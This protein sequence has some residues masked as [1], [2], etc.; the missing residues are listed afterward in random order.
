M[1]LRNWEERLWETLLR[2][3]WRLFTTIWN[4]WLNSAIYPLL[5]L[6]PDTRASWEGRL[7]PVY[8]SVAQRNWKSLRKEHLASNH[9]DLYILSDSVDQFITWASGFVSYT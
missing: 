2:K 3:D 6:V 8:L 1:S 5:Y 7:N 9:V 4:H